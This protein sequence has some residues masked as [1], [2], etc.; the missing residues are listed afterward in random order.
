MSRIIL[1]NADDWGLSQQIHDSI[2][3]LH[4]ADALDAAGIMMGQPFTAQAV[5]YAASNSKLITGI[6]LFASDRDCKPLSVRNWPFLWPEDFWVNTAVA[7][8]AV[9]NLILAEVDAQLLAWRDTELPLRFV[10]SHFHFHAHH[11]L[12]HKIVGLILNHFPDFDGLIRLG[13]SRTIMGGMR[14]V[15]D[16]LADLIESGIFTRDWRGKNNDS[17]F[18]FDQT[19]ANFAPSVAAACAGLGDGF[20]EFFFHPGRSWKLTENGTDHIALLELATL[21]PPAAR[22]VNLLLPP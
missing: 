2:T 10:N 22:N 13:D 16:P 4:Q 7:L 20:H 9:E 15:L 8:P 17:L 12:F 1:F 5:S 11:R 3:E 6:H 14:G 21:L 19:F 18:G